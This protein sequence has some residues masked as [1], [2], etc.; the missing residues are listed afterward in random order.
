MNSIPSLPHLV[1]LLSHS[2][3]RIFP[4]RFLFNQPYLFLRLVSNVFH[5]QLTTIKLQISPFIIMRIH[6]PVNEFVTAGFSKLHIRWIFHIITV[7]VDDP[8]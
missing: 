7:L 3:L 6:N 8:G 1:H 5:R 2:F 4:Q